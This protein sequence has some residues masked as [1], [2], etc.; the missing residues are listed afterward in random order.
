MHVE[1]EQRS[2]FS[3]GFIDDKVVECEVLE[4]KGQPLHW[5]ESP[6]TY[7]WNDEVLLVTREKLAQVV[8]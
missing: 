8:R 6:H 1:I 3:T 7:L 4:V 5:N 2:G